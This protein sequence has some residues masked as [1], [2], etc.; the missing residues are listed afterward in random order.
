MKRPSLSKVV[1][2]AM[3]FT[4]G[5]ELGALFN[6]HGPMV[7]AATPLLAALAGFA[8]RGLLHDVLVTLAAKIFA[9]AYGQRAVKAVLA[10]GVSNLA[11][12]RNSQ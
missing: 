4:A 8:L 12:E 1:W 2:P 9:S 10:D 5:L 7:P 11:P 3:L 6:P